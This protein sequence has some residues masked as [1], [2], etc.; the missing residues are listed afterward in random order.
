[1]S[2]PRIVLFDLETMPNFNEAMKVWPQISDYPG[3]TLKAQISTIICAGYKVYGE[4]KTN[5]INA[6]DFDEWTKDINSDKRVCKA[7]YEVLKNADAVITHNG[8]RFDWKFLQTRLL[9][10]GLPALP[11]IPHID[12][13]LVARK[14]LYAFN[15]RLGNLG[16]FFLADDKLENGGWDLW[17][18]VSRR[19]K[20]AMR[21]MVKYCKQD[22]D[23]LEKLFRKLRPF[24]KNIPNYNVF[25]PEYASGKR[26]CP[27]CGSTRLK[28]HGWKHTK[29]QSYRR[30]RCI[31]C[32]TFSRTDKSGKM[33]RSI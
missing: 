6:W 25:A 18:R 1:M 16:K 21:L 10:H 20:Q 15:N 29:T 24:I 8:K 27:S 30:L 26:V 12:T 3:R 13:A 2:E 17:V 7:I 4:N 23:L 19:E 11:D 22:V 32:G 9:K 5:C 14:N 31:E 28:S 33:P